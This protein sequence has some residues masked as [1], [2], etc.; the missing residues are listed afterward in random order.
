MRWL[1]NSNNVKKMFSQL[2]QENDVNRSR[3]VDFIP[4]QRHEGKSSYIWFS[5]VDPMTGRLKR[6]KYML[7]RFRRGRERDIAAH[8]IISN[9]YNKV[10]HGWNVWAPSNT[11]R[12]DTAVSDVIERYRAYIKN[13]HRKGVLKKKTLYDYSSR[14]RILEEYLNESVTPI[15]M[16]YQLDQ[17][18]WTDFFDYLLLDRD[19]SA[20][21]RNNYRTWSSTFCSWLVEKRYLGDNPIQHIHELPEHDKFRQPLEFD[22]LSKLGNYLREHNKPFLLAVMMEYFTAIRP[23]ELSFIRLK[24]ISIAEG[25]VF[26]SSQISKN[27]R[28]GKIKLPTKVIKLMLELNVFSH[29]DNCFLFG[30]GFLPSEKRQDPRA[31]RKQFS[32]VR[33]ALGFPDTYKFYSLKDSGLRDIANAVGIEVAQKQARHSSVQTTNLY[34]KGKGMKVYDVLADFEGY[35]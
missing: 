8:R 18:F 28:D 20:K 25:S 13:V 33:E 7:D 22:D 21:S 29:H 2:E 23:G 9:I 17:T 10:S 12:S 26:V 27:R 16:C 35:L 14:L 4:P 31:F 11:N 19:L 1:Y 5:Q 34:L 15:R 6:K 30:K 3:I 24:D 32:L